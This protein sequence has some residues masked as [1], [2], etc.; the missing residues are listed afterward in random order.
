VPIFLRQALANEPLTI[1]GDGGQ[2]RDFIFVKDIAAACLFV[3]TTPGLTGV[4]NAGY[5]SAVT[6]LELA[7]RIIAL[8]GSRSTIRHAPERAGDVRHS[9]ANVDKLRAAGFQPSGSL[10]SGLAAMM[11]ARRR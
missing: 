4:F 8:T 2:T 11:A 7:R 6:V 5:G 9:C 3:A 10:E 1:F